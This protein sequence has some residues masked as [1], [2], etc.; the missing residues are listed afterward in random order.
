[1]TTLSA[2]RR[3]LGVA[4]LALA[5]TTVGAQNVGTYTAGGGTGSWGAAITANSLTQVSISDFSTF[6]F[7]SVQ[8]LALN[9][10]DNDAIENAVTGRFADLVT[11]VTN[12]GKLIIHDRWATSTAWIPG[13]GSMM[14]T[15]DLGSD[16]QVVTG[17][18]AVV[19]GPFGTITNT[20]LDNGNLSNHG[21]A[22]MLPPGATTFLSVQGDPNKAVSF[23]YGL[24]SGFVFY[25]TIPIDFYQSGV[26]NNPPGDDMRNVYAPNVLGYMNGLNTNVVPEPSTFALSA[27]G[28]AGLAAVVRRRRRATA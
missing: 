24:G 3:A 19:N 10:A 21:Y 5:S 18:N 7:G 14:L 28:L 13:A 4:S 25:S 23:V 16:L 11:W 20:S 1:M 22:Q 15:R 12:G 26:G 2:V 17:G 9:N 8:I 6:N 27:A